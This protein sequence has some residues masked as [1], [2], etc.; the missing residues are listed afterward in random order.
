MPG[1]GC[2]GGATARRLGGRGPF[3]VDSFHATPVG[4]MLN[5]ETIAR[6]RFLSQQDQITYQE[7]ARLMSRE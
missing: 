3:E 1:E 7:C 5:F 4:L 2:N 6:D